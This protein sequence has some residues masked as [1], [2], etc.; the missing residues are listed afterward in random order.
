MQFQYNSL[1]SIL[2]LFDKDLNSVFHMKI[3]KREWKLRDHVIF[4]IKITLNFFIFILFL[5]FE[6][7]RIKFPL[8]ESFIFHNFPLINS[9]IIVCW[10]F[11]FHI[12]YDEWFSTDHHKN[13]PHWIFGYYWR[14]EKRFWRS[15][16]FE[17]P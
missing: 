2:I 3:L 8:M 14:E 13:T 4:S 12:P 15:K 9:N 7:P 16:I 10:I 5:I 11:I 6:F 17:C 1:E